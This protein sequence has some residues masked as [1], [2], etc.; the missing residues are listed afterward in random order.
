MNPQNYNQTALKTFQGKNHTITVFD[1]G[2]PNIDNTVVESFGEEWSKFHSFSREEVTRIGNEYFDIITPDIVNKTSYGI[3]IG[4][5]SGRWTQF[6]LDRIGFMEAVDPSQ[7]IVAADELLAGYKNVRL[8]Q[9]S[10]D[11]LPFD[12]NTFDFAMSIGVLHH[13]PDTRRAMLDCVKKVK[14]GGYFYTYLYYSLDN[15]G[16]LHKGMLGIATGFRWVI[17]RLPSVLK[18]L[19]CDIIAILVYMPFVL[20]ARL[21]AA[22]GWQKLATKVPLG[23]YRNKSFYIIRNDALDRFGTKLEQRFSRVEVI[24][25]MEA[26]GLTDVLVSPNSPYW[27][28][29]GRK[30]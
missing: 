20:V 14:P 26:A 15:R 25:M 16:W 1:T 11:N 28:A 17:S 23:D 6:M 4:C 21:F 27:H 18:K 10:V 24:E 3:D 30:K 12:D 7:A 9:A 22:L 2:G 13:I 29:V 19:V 5:G 8:T